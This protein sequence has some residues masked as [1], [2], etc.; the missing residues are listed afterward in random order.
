MLTLGTS[1]DNSRASY[2]ICKNLAQIDYMPKTYTLLLRDEYQS[3]G[4]DITK[5]FLKM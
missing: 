2:M 3:I 4:I 5:Y 1:G